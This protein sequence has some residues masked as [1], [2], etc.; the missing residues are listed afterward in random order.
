MRCAG[1]PYALWSLVVIILTLNNLVGSSS[2]NH[3]IDDVNG[4]SVTGALVQYLPVVPPSDTP[5]WF[6]QT[7][8]AGCADVPDATFAFDNTWSAALYQEN[9]GSLSVSMK[10]T[11]A[12]FVIVLVSLLP[13]Y[14]HRHLCFLYS[15][16]LPCG[17]GPCKRSAL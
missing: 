3:T 1:P 11:G 10:F 2:V 17:F 15:P 7:S 12:W 16:Q 13:A 9:V 8:C 6:N 5:L 4:D 14:R